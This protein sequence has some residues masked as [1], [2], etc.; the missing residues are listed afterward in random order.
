M[1]VNK[2]LE[3]WDGRE[4]EEMFYAPPNIFMNGINANNN[5]STIFSNTVI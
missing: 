2:V 1:I 4:K 3:L 5:N